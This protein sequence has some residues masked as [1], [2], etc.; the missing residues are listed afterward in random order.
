M[1]HRRGEGDATTETEIGG[2]KSQNLGMLMAS[3]SW[4]RQGMTPPQR[5]QRE[6]SSAA[7]LI[8]FQ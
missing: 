5:L 7:T 6:Y 4:K 1:T 3:R 8:L 2:E